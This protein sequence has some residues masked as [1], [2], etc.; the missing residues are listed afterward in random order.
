MAVELGLFW[1]DALGWPL[2]WDEGVQTAF[3]SPA[4]GTKIAWD[5]EDDGTEC[6]PDEQRFELIA[7]DLTAELRRLVSLG[8]TILAE[9]RHAVTLADPDGSV[10]SVREDG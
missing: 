5:G 4:G 9:E 1:R 6:V 10:F 3:Q 7:D 8:A 2:V